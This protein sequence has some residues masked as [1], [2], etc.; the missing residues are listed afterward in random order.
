MIRIIP[1]PKRYSTGSLLLN[2]K[3]LT[4]GFV[5]VAK[6]RLKAN[7]RPAGNVGLNERS[8][9]DVRAARK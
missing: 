8:K 5:P 6:K 9:R 3:R 1:E 7:L 4:H 2:L